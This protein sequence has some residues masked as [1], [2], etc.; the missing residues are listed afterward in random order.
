MRHVNGYVTGEQCEAL[1]GSPQEA[2]KDLAD[3]RYEASQAE[4]GRQRRRM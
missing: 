2:C 1:S 4:A 3:E